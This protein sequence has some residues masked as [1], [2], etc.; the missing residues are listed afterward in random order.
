[1]N[2]KSYSILRYTTRKLVPLYKL[3]LL[4]KI[5]TTFKY[6]YIK[7]FKDTI[8]LNKKIAAERKYYNKSV[9]LKKFLIDTIRNV[10]ANYIVVQIDNSYLDVLDDVLNNCIELSD[11]D[12]IPVKLNPN[13]RKFVRNAHPLLKIVYKGGVLIDF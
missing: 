7:N 10:N 2:R 12:I 8:E 6:L 13:I 3:D 5:S 1:M 11:Y 9:V 4:G